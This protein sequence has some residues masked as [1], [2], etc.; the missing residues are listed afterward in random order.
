MRR[1]DSAD[2]RTETDVAE[3]YYQS[4]NTESARVGHE[5]LNSGKNVSDRI[6]REREKKF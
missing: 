3:S 1:F 4:W 2:S 6:S 5:P